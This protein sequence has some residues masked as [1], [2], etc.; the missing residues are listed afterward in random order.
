MLDPD[1][2]RIFAKALDAAARLAEDYHG[3][4]RLQSNSDEDIT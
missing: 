4:I 1:K 2:A 3:R